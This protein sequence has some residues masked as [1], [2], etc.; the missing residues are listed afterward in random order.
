MAGYMADY[1][2]QALAYLGDAVIELL[3]RKEAVTRLPGGASGDLNS[4]AR[5]RVTAPA[6]S[7]AAERII[8]YLTEEENGVYHRGRNNIH[9]AIPHSA[10]AAQYR[11]ATALECVFGWLYLRGDTAR[12]R[13][14]YSLAYN[15]EDSELNDAQI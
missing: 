3:V 11:R 6:Q 14:L 9:N 1:S 13:E 10:T 7:D 8:P 4:F 15:T 2:T 5:T 12:I